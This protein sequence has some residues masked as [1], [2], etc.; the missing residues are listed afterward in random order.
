MDGLGNP[1]GVPK[2]LHLTE[3]NQ[4]WQQMRFQSLAGRNFGECCKL[5]Q[6]EITNHYP[7]AAKLVKWEREKTVDMKGPMSAAQKKVLSYAYLL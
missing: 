7:N 1:V 5:L 2:T 3:S 4:V 6:L